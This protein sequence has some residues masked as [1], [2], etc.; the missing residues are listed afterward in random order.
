M[1]DIR[2]AILRGTAEAARV[3]SELNSRDRWE[4]TGGRIDVFAAIDHYNLPLMF[5]PLEGLLG[6]YLVNPAPGILINTKR[7]LSV[8]RYTA[9]HEFGHFRLNHAPSIDEEDMIS[10]SPYASRAG[11]DEREIEADA[12]AIGFLLPQWLVGAQMRKHGWSRNEMREPTPVYQLA[13]RAGISYEATCYALQKYNVIDASTCSHLVSIQ[14]KSI[15]QGIIP[16]YKPENWYLDVWHLSEGDDGLFLEATVGDIIE[17]ALPE[18]AGGG[19]LWDV[20]GIAKSDFEVVSDG[21]NALGDQGTV[22][23]HVVRRLTARAK[24]RGFGSVRFVESRPWEQ[25]TEPL[26]SYQFS[27]DISEFGQRGLFQ[28]QRER[29]IGER[30]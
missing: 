9:A 26:S 7:P 28:A 8:R 13:L 25:D 5:Q 6:A 24:A 4:Q 16:E 21:R 11:Y 22:G 17:V 3:H 1:A 30:G 29:I 19:Y 23:A 15:K 2:G 27:Y 10:R 20:G 14:P 18:H 12:F